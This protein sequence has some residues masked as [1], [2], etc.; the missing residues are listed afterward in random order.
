MG[1]APAFVQNL[2]HDPVFSKVCPN[3]KSLPFPSALPD[4][5]KVSAHQ[6][7]EEERRL[8]AS[9]KNY[10]IHGKPPS[11]RRNGPIPANGVKFRDRGYPT[12]HSQQPGGWFHIGPSMFF[13]E[14]RSR[15]SAKRINQKCIEWTGLS[16]ISPA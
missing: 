12:D 11:G 5:L 4:S 3:A 14:L 1:W 6:F 13:A 10:R 15:F 2:F 16:H 9:C 7:W 8:S